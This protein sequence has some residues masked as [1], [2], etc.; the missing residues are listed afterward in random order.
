M[1]SAAASAFSRTDLVTG[2]FVAACV[3]QVA[4][5][6]FELEADVYEVLAWHGPGVYTVQVEVDPRIGQIASGESRWRR[7]PACLGRARP[8]KKVTHTE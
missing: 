3:C 5:E 2:V 8:S 4:G 7:C 6:E 1:F